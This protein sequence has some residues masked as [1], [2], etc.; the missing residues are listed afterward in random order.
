MDKAGH[1]RVLGRP[2][3]GRLVVL[4][5]AGHINEESGH[6]PRPLALELYDAL[7]AI[8]R[9]DPLGSLTAA[10]THARLGRAPFSLATRGRGVNRLQS[11]KSNKQR[12]IRYF[13]AWE[14]ES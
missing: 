5:A 1:G 2:L 11:M 14:E 9:D 7:C 10:S 12:R 3:G 13:E 6:G 4:E 8:Q